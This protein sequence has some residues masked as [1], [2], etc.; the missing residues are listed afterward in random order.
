MDFIFTHII[1]STV[2]GR[3]SIKDYKVCASFKCIL[4]EMICRKM[5]IVFPIDRY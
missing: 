3:I 5:Q 4:D 1:S 2:F